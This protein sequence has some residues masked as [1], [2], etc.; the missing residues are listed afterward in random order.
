MSH[1]NVSKRTVASEIYIYGE[2]K[3]KRCYWYRSN[4]HHL[5]ESFV[6]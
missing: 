6:Y 5:S 1:M 2:L 3:E 4:F